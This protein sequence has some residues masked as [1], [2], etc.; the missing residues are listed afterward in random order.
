MNAPEFMDDRVIG[1]NRFGKRCS[2]EPNGPGKGRDGKVPMPPKVNTGNFGVAAK[3][4]VAKGSKEDAGKDV[5]TEKGSDRIEIDVLDL[6]CGSGDKRCEGSSCGNTN[7]SR[8]DKDGCD[9]S[10]HRGD[11]RGGDKESGHSLGVRCGCDRG[12][13]RGEN[14]E[15]DVDHYGGKGEMMGKDVAT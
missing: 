15:G 4:K 11:K 13:Q 9:S 5:Q 3:R 6:D 12:V 2:D 1:N 14:S 10:D 8:C 7:L